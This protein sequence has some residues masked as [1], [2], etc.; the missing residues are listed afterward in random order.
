MIYQFRITS[1]ESHS[2]NLMME[3]GCDNSFFDIHETIQNNLEYETHQLASFFI[4]DARGSKLKEVSQLD[5]G[6]DG[7]VYHIMQKTKLSDL[8]KLKGQKIIYTFDFIN[9]RSF[10]IELT[11]I[12]MEK[13]LKEPLVTLKKGEAPAQVLISE[14]SEPASTNLRDEE[15]IMDFGILDDYSELYGEMEDY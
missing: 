6:S 5:T 7:G 4:S 12:V 13:S 8:I 2:F 3:A 14:T 1:P 10:Y 11:E 9:D 15:V